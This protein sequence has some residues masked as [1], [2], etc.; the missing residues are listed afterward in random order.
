LSSWVTN[1]KRQNRQTAS[2]IFKLWPVD[3]P[4]PKKI[5][6]KTQKSIKV[7]Y[8]LSHLNEAIQN[9]F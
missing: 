4:R 3:Y 5:H 2:G 9:P 1:P 6:G 8:F 7:I